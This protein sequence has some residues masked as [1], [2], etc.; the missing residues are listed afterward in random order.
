MLLNRR[1]LVHSNECASNF[2]HRFKPCVHL[3]FFD[4]FTAFGCRYSL[5]HGGKEAGF[6]VKITSDNTRYQAF[7]HSS[8]F[9]GNLRKLRL[10][11]RRELNF[12]GSRL[13]NYRLRGNVLGR[14]ASD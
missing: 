12:H 9:G 4:K 7:R 6:F 8:S 3:F 2:E 10:L 1:Q 5:F 14:S 11:L 13:R